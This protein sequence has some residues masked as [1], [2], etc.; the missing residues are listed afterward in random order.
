MEN[1]EVYRLQSPIENITEVQIPLGVAQIAD[2]L[3]AQ[4]I[5]VAR[6]GRSLEGDKHLTGIPGVMDAVIRFGF[7][8]VSLPIVRDAVTLSVAEAIASN[9]DQYFPLREDIVRTS[10]LVWSRY[11]RVK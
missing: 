4:G 2:G 11:N 6:L 3:I 9:D 5:G 7:Q 1:Y 8:R 10:R